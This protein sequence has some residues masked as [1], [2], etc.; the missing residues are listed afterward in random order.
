MVGKRRRQYIDA[1]PLLRTVAV[2][3]VTFQGNGSRR[4]NVLF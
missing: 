1:N 3:D 2:S 4:W